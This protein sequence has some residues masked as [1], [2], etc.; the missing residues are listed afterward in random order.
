M[1]IIHISQI[2]NNSMEKI[3]EITTV[4]EVCMCDPNYHKLC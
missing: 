4:N 1:S 3:K 2:M